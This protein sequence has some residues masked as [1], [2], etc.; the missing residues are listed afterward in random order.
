MLNNPA[1]IRPGHARTL[2]W[3][4]VQPG[5]SL[6][7]LRGEIFQSLVLNSAVSLTM[8]FPSGLCL[9]PGSSETYM[10]SHLGVVTGPEYLEG[11][12]PI[13]IY[14]K[15]QFSSN[16]CKQWGKQQRTYLQ[17]IHLS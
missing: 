2:N 12:Y 10:I 13:P 8:E 11:N 7:E 1:S 9:F 14:L 4:C 3:L 5:E 17:V 6:S 16:A 15:V